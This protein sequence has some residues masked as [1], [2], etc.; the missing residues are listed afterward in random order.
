MGH[1]ST[2]NEIFN[3]ENSGSESSILCHLVNDKATG[4][5]R[6]EIGNHP[7]LDK[8]LTSQAPVLK[9]KDEEFDINKDNQASNNSTKITDDNQIINDQAE[10]TGD[11]S[12]KNLV[13]YSSYCYAEGTIEEQNEDSFQNKSPVGLV[14]KNE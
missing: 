10:N 14:N 6:E 9:S 2:T 3:P 1:G 7:T 5:K 4:D 12:N 13:E 8:D 11:Y